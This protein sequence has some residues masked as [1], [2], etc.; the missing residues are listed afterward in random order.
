MK[1]LFSDESKFVKVHSS[2]RVYVRHM[3]GE[4]HLIKCTRFTVQTGSDFLM[5]WGCFSWHGMG[6]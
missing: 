4:Q 5:I 3:T 1:V 2:G 6:P